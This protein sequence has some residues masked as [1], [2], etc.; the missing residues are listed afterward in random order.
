MFGLGHVNS[1]EL[2]ELIQWGIVVQRISEF[3][4]AE[5]AIQGRAVQLQAMTLVD[6]PLRA[7]PD[8]HCLN[9]GPPTLKWSKLELVTYL[10]SN[11]WVEAPPAPYLEKDGPRTF[12]GSALKQPKA[13]WM[14]LARCASI[15]SKRGNLRR[16]FHAGKE[17]YYLCLLRMGDLSEIA[18]WDEQGELEDKSSTNLRAMLKDQPV[19]DDDDGWADEAEHSEE[20]DPDPPL[21]LPAPAGGAVAPPLVPQIAQRPVKHFRSGGQRVSVNFDNYSHPTGELRCYVNCRVHGPQCRLYAFVKNHP[22]IEEAM[23][24]VL[25]WGL[26]E[27]SADAHKALRPTVGQVQDALMLVR[28]GA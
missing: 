13:Y 24:Y 21:A 6:R 16:I 17:A 11:G 18:R 1:L 3:G 8:G 4:D 20:E 2:E 27:A 23:A 12:H 15:F 25:A 5:Y 19:N 14:C 26:L 9:E 10:L 7:V 28:E 22:C